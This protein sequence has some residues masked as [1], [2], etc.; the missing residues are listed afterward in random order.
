MVTPAGTDKARLEPGQL[1]VADF[2]SQE[3]PPRASSELRVHLEVYRQHPGVRAVVHAH[4]PR[5]QALDTMGREPRCSLL[6]E[7]QALLGAVG[8]VRA[9]SPGSRELAVSVAEKIGDAPVCVMARHGALA[10]A[11][12]MDRAILRMLLLERLAGLTL[13]ACGR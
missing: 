12:S 13:A 8:R 11:S 3:L 6:L 10:V 2:E 5:V 7:A 9:L 4:P 1:I